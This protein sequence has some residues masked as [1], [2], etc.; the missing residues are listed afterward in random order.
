MIAAIKQFLEEGLSP[1]RRRPGRDA[2][3]LA[4]AALLIEMMCVDYREDETERETIGRAVGKMFGLTPEDSAQLVSR[5]ESQLRQA[6]DYYEF[7]SRINQGFTAQQKEALVEA[8]WRVAYADGNIDMY[9][10]HYLRKIAD[11]LY[12]PQHSFIAAKLRVCR[13]KD[14]WQADSVSPDL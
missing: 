11:L 8:L 14:G 4:A 7:T 13:P 10:R 12:I 6:T 9:E 1:E 3:Q 5:A 2:L